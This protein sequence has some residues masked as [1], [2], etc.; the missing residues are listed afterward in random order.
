MRVAQNRVVQ[1]HYTLTDEE[2]KTIEEL[3]V[4]NTT[5]SPDKNLFTPLE[6]L[7]KLNPELNEWIYER[8]NRTEN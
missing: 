4:L 2:G 8:I 1:M 7:S 3:E 5:R 6:I